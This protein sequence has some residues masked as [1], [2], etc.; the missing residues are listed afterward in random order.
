VSKGQVTVELFRGRLRLRWRWQ[1]KRQTLTI[2]ADTTMGRAVANQI[3]RS[4]EADM[5]TGNYD[6]SRKKYRVDAE[7][8]IEVVP[9]VQGFLKTIDRPSPKHHALLNHVKREWSDREVESVG[10]KEARL[11]LEGLRVSAATFSAYLFILRAIW[12]W[13]K[14]EPNPWDAIVAP[15]ISRLAPDPFTQEEVEQI[16]KAFEDSYYLNYVKVLLAT[17]CRP[18]EVSALQWGDVKSNGMLTISRS[19]SDR[20][21]RVKE[22]KTGKIRQIPMT[23]GLRSLLDAL[24][25]EHQCS[26]L[27]LPG[28]QGGHINPKDFLTKHWRSTLKRAGIR[29]RP[30]YRTRHTVWSHAIAEGM[31]VAEAA[32]YAGNRSETMIRHYVGRVSRSKL[33]DFLNSNQESDRSID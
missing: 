15:K 16:L 11:F 9:M 32:E 26:D 14:I 20:E 31:P 5:L 3:A 4:I 28:K 2:G 24:T 23:S 27:I 7:P 22:T 1:K 25:G 30:T 21:H 33:P 17:G 10:V 8:E 6:E 19:W 12:E 13:K 29:Y 18:G